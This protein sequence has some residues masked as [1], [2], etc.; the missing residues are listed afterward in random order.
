MLSRHGDRIFKSYHTDEK[1][2]IAKKPNIH[3]SKS[4]PN[5]M[6]TNCKIHIM[7][8][9]WQVTTTKYKNDF[10]LQID[11]QSDGTAIAC[12]PSGP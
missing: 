3:M 4:T 8:S 11:P 5:F 1:Q 10:F 7:P 2:C 9:R 6:G 12:S